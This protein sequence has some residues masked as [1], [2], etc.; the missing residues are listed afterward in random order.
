MKLSA[1][2]V[3]ESVIPRLESFGVPPVELLEEADLSLARLQDVG[4]VY[5]EP[6]PLADAACRILGDPLG[7]V[8]YYLG[9]PPQLPH[10]LSLL[11]AAQD[12][13]RNALECICDYRSVVVSGLVLELSDRDSDASVL[14]HQ[15]EESAEPIVTEWAMAALIS[16]VRA[17][18]AGRASLSAV[19]FRHP[20]RTK[21]ESYD[22]LF[23]VP[24]RFGQAIDGL[25]LGP[26][27]LELPLD[28][29]PSNRALRRELERLVQDRLQGAVSLL[30]LRS[31]CLDELR[32]QVSRGEQ[33]TLAHVAE[34][35]GVRPRTFQ[36]QLEQQGVSYR[37]LKTEV[38]IER[39]KELL[40]DEKTAIAEV[41]ERTGFASAG[42][43]CRAFKRATGMTPLSYRR[44]RRMV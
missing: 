3:L 22:Q 8:R 43:L 23:G 13:L 27:D 4:G 5:V 20:P 38:V 36:R 44:V 15:D 40:T 39:V 34:V 12:T 25:R 14:L 32:S 21:E 41:A 30:D 33:P 10:A 24:V 42:A 9:N 35:L 28:L 31:R 26:R 16:F 7:L 37:Q 1:Q 19:W 29:V 17:S 2:H 11:A 6:S 18:T